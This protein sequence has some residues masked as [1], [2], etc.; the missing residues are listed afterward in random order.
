VQGAERRVA[1]TSHFMSA[2]VEKPGQAMEGTRR[3]KCCACSWGAYIEDNVWATLG[4]ASGT[5]QAKAHRCALPVGR[6]I[7]M[8]ISTESS[9]LTLAH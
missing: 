8:G 1:P 4:R 5:S 7:T 2:T 6:E 9:R 3:Q